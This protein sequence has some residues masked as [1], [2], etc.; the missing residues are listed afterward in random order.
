MIF[1]QLTIIGLIFISACSHNSRNNKNL[2]NYED[3]LLLVDSCE[4]TNKENKDYQ[5]TDYGEPFPIDV[6]KECIYYN[7]GKEPQKNIIINELFG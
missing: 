4:Q 6:I 3:S 1:F 7:G 5:F 2:L